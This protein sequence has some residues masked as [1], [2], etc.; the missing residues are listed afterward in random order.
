[1]SFQNQNADNAQELYRLPVF[2]TEKIFGFDTLNIRDLGALKAFARCQ[3]SKMKDVMDLAE[4]LRQRV[5]VQEIISTA[6]QIF[7]YDFSAKEFVNSCLNID[8]ILENALDEN[9]DFLNDK[10]IDFYTNYLKSK[11]KEYYV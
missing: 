6:E 11:L 4:I 2:P 9:I 8:D 3:R 7:G 5:P 10:D 1:M